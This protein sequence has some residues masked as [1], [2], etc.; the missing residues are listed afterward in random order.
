MPL[1]DPRKTGAANLFLTFDEDLYI[2]RAA[3]SDGEEGT[4]R[5]DGD[6]VGQVRREPDVAG[7][8]VLAPVSDRQTAPAA[9]AFRGSWRDTLRALS[10]GRDD[11]GQ[12]AS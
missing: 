11:A 12:L 2:H 7:F 10:D 1:D 6:T 4:H 3:P 8:A 9:A 5:L